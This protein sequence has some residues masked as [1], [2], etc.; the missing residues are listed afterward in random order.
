[1][2]LVLVSMDTWYLM[3]SVK[4]S[5]RCLQGAVRSPSPKLRQR[6]CMDMAR[7]GGVVKNERT[8]LVTNDGKELAI[9][10]IGLVGHVE[11]HLKVL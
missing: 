4:Y 11:I 10:E 9:L 8:Y 6:V 3:V 5:R 1:M 7:D 2:L